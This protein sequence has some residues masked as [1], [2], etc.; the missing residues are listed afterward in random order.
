MSVPWD[1][2]VDEGGRARTLGLLQLKEE[3]I[4]RPVTLQQHHKRPQTDT[5]HAD[6]L[7]G[8]VDHY[9]GAEHTMPMRR[10]SFQILLQAV[11]ETL[12]LLIRYVHHD[13][14]LVRNVA[15]TVAFTS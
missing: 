1:V 12:L 13:R 11:D 5:S 10:K 15:H 4:V 2:T 6:H 9:V 3:H 8:H 14:R 7:M